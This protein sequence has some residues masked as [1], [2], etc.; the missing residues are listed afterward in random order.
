MKVNKGYVYPSQEVARIADP[1]C[2]FAALSAKQN[3]GG[4]LF[5][6]RLIPAKLTYGKVRVSG[7]GVYFY[8]SY[9][10]QIRYKVLAK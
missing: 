2:K 7:P 4:D 1:I 9:F 10:E 8:Y 6:P 5:G 3:G